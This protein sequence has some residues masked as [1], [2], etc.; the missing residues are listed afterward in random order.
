MSGEFSGTL[1]DHIRIERTLGQRD[2]IGSAAEQTE[3]VGKYRA[4]VQA[5]ANGSQAQGESRSARQQWR[6]VLRETGSILPGDW[7][8]WG[9]R[10][11]IVNTVSADRRL[12]P[13]TILLA[14][15]KG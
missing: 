10:R 13:K 9:N 7:L 3:L 11:M 1:R 12:L 4:A 8:I 2:A 6:I 15:E 14:E 5:A